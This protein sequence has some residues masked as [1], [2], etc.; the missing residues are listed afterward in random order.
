VKLGRIARTFLIIFDLTLLT[1]IINSVVT[2]QVPR[3]KPAFWIAVAIEIFLGY[4]TYWFWMRSLL[5]PGFNPD[6]IKFL[7]TLVIGAALS[8][9]I[10]LIPF[11]W[12]QP[13]TTADRFYF[14]TFV[15]LLIYSSFVIDKY[16]KKNRV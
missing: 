5:K 15:T 6:K 16:L 8:Q 3:D 1:Y 9:L 2:S 7:V 13:A 11:S 4:L 10:Y 12:L 14:G